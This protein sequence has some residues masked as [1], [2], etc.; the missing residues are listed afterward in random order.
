MRVPE[1]KDREKG[2]ERIF[3]EMIAA[4]FPNLTKGMNINI[5]EPQQSSSKMNS[6]RHYN[7]TFN[8]QRDYWKQQGRHNT[9]PTSIKAPQ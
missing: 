4:K 2:V 3:E 7:Q 9:L 5:Q 6:K 1:E 8:T